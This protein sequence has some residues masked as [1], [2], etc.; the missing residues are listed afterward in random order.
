MIVKTGYRT[1]L[2]WWSHT[3][4]GSLSKHNKLVWIHASC[5]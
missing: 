1:L 3:A 2:I 4:F 5:C